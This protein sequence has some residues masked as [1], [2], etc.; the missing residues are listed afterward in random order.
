[1]DSRAKLKP[2]PREIGRGCE[3]AH[4]QCPECRTPP[5]RRRLRTDAVTFYEVRKRR[6]WRE[7]P[8]SLRKLSRE[9]GFAH[10]GATTVRNGTYSVARRYL[11]ELSEF[12]FI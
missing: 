9:S 2:A 8:D 3:G 1:M 12:K 4:S 5:P 11:V 6:K 10:G 7:W